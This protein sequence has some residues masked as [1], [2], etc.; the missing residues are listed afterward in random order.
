MFTNI[1][2]KCPICNSQINQKIEIPQPNYSA[3]KLSDSGAEVDDYIEC[4]KCDF[5]AVCSGTNSFYELFLECDEIADGS[6]TYEQASYEYEKY[7]LDIDVEESGFQNILNDKEITNLYHFTKVENILGIFDKG[8]KPRC[9]LD[10]GTFSPSDF[11]RFDG[12]LNA[13]CL[14]VSFPQYRMFYLKRRENY[15]QKWVV[16]EFYSSIIDN[17]D[18]AFFE[19]NA[20]SNAVK[21]EVLENRKSVTAFEKMFG[22]PSHRNSLVL[23]D[24][25]PLDEQAEVLV[26]DTI[27]V[28]HLKAVHFLSEADKN[29]FSYSLEPSMCFVT[30]K[31]FE[32]RCDY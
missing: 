14:S 24:K 29:D 11:S 7:E 13:N 16:L 21:G 19:H 27:E 5:S 28:S 15:Q 8:L 32:N 3:E 6:F 31:L 22:E 18:C 1:E 4:T 23:P 12:L 2:A 26:F 9:Y 25:Y 17:Y 20:A 10:I 30:P